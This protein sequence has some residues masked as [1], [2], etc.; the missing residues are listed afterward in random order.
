MEQAFIRVAD[1]SFGM[2]RCQSQLL[3]CLL[4]IVFCQVLQDL[5]TA[6]RTPVTPSH[7]EEK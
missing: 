2:T 5:I 4:S 3:L 7:N 1:G 6:A